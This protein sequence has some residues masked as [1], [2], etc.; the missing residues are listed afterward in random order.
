MKLLL[1]VNEQLEFL[2]E[3]TAD[4][5]Q[6]YYVQG[7]FLEGDIKNKNGRIYPASTLAKAVRVYE[8]NYIKKN[9]S[10]G[11][12]NHP[13]SPSINLDR[14]SHIITELKQEGSNFIGKARILTET[15]MG[16]M[17]KALID[18]RCT[19]GTSSRGLGSLRESR[20][21]NV[22][23]D[24]LYFATAGD[25]VSDP[26]APSAFLSAL[27]EEADWVMRNGEWVP[28]YRE[29]VLEKLDEIVASRPSKEEKE[30]QFFKLFEGYM[31]RLTK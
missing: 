15:P 17:A 28:V 29:A 23:Q 12:L 16:K 3:Q 6:N 1:E 7:I 8:D 27:K 9:R 26:S 20:D 10:Y 14:V 13:A 2:K 4:G 22:V 31:N 24:D 30:R 21:G 25:L 19:L 5:K 11:E 18:E